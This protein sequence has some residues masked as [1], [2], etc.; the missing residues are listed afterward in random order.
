V[1]EYY[2][3]PVIPQFPVSRIPPYVLKS[4]IDSPPRRETLGHFIDERVFVSNH[5]AWHIQVDGERL[6]GPSTYHAPSREIRELAS[7]IIRDY[8]RP[9][10]YIVERADTFFQKHLAGRF[11]IG[12]HIRGTDALV[13]TDRHVRQTQVN[14]RKYAA[15][16]RRLLWIHPKAL[17]FVASDAQASVDRIREWF[18]RRVIDYE[19]IR[20]QGGEI[21]GRGPAGGMMPAYLTADRDRAAKNGEEA[22]IEYLLLRQSDYLVHNLSS[23]PRMVLLTVPDMPET[24]V[25]KPSLLG[26]RLAIWRHRSKLVYDTIWGKPVGSWHRLLH[27]LWTTKRAA[28]RMAQRRK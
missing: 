22:V 4:I 11:I 17:I 25:D 20:Y 6:R 15:V 13:D 14:F 21:V 12:V 24:N 28:R 8:I 2:F 27:E 23:I 26:R 19:S 18:G 16:V 7:A 3:E 1:W 9:R 5:T 10:N